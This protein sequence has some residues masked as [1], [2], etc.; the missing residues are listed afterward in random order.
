[1]FYGELK[2]TPV[3]VRIAIYGR[4]TTDRLIPLRWHSLLSEL[5]MESVNILFLTLRV[6]MNLNRRP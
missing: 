4:F 5:Q 2:E 3:V 1:M 6:N